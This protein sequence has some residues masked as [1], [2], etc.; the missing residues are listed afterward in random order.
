MHFFI[1]SLED[2]VLSEFSIGNF[3]FVLIYNTKGRQFDGLS[4]DTYRTGNAHLRD[5]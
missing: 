2:R 5:T 4:M 3:I 1:G